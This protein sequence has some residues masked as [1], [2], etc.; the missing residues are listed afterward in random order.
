MDWGR[1]FFKSGDA[2]LPD[3][4]SDVLG[5]DLIGSSKKTFYISYWSF[6]HLISGILCGHLIRKKNFYLYIASDENTNYYATLLIIH[7]IWEAWQVIIGQSFPLTLVGPGNL[8]DTVVDTVMF[9][10]GGCV[11]NWIYINKVV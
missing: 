9:M 2:F 10:L 4:I 1:I 6:I 7:T 8:I 11:Y 5:I 3:Y